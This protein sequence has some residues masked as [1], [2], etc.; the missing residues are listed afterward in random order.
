M[1]VL[2]FLSVPFWEFGETQ[3]ELTRPKKKS[4]PII[5]PAISRFRGFRSTSDFIARV[6]VLTPASAG[7]EE[8]G[9][10]WLGLRCP[11]P[12]RS[13]EMLV[14][15]CFNPRWWANPRIASRSDG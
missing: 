1:V 14:A 10:R 12:S 6:E 15:V 5:P 8:F 4:K 11:K 9:H 13:D 7:R 2:G 3:E